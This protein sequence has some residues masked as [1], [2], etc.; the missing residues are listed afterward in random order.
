M[1]P[2][3]TDQFDQRLLELVNQERS[4]RGLQSLSLSQKLD[5]AADQYS[6]RMASGDFFSHTDPE[7][8]STVSTRVTEFGYQWKTVG[9]N[10]AAGQTSAEEVFNA[11]MN[12]SGHRANILN[13]NYTHMGLG[14]AY[15]ANDTGNFN[16]KHYWTQVFAAGDS[17]PGEYVAD[18]TE[19][20]TSPDPVTSDPTNLNLNGGVGNDI[21]QGGDGNDVLVGVDPTMANAGKG[22]IDILF[23][24]SGS[25]VFVLGDESQAYYNDDLLNNRG[26]AD[27]AL[28][29]DFKVGED[30][31]ELH[32]G[33]YSLGSSPWGMPSGTAIYVNESQNSYELIAIVEDISASTLFSNVGISFSFV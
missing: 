8:G 11:W 20:S 28:I 3:A 12:S 33:S 21:L 18:T 10:I 13:P 24:G 29:K 27:Y 17:N 4:K 26:L 31:I 19:G 2:I 30:V 23:G 7:N 22:E 14:Y 25:D 32:R 1:T 9:E 15:L 16:Y 5:Q 6:N